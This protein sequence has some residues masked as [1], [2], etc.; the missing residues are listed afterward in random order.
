MCS[1][2]RAPIPRQTLPQKHADPVPAILSFN[3]EIFLVMTETMDGV[4]IFMELN[5][6][7]RVLQVLG[8][9]RPLPRASDSLSLP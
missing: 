8:V 1:C 3:C 6:D 2:P 5:L 9:G 4:G 7:P